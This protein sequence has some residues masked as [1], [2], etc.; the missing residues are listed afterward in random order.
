MIHLATKPLYS[1]SKDPFKTLRQI[2]IYL[3]TGLRLVPALSSVVVNRVIDVFLGTT[4]I[5]E[6]I[7]AILPEERKATVCDANSVA[8]I[9]QGNPPANAVL[10][11]ADSEE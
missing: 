5:D 4:F 11:A 1:A 3:R 6:N 8:I 2:C 10:N 7:L 9:K